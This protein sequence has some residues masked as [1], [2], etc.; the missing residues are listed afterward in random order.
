M[1]MV[2]LQYVQE[3]KEQERVGVRRLLRYTGTLYAEDVM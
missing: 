3:E 2:Y 1:N